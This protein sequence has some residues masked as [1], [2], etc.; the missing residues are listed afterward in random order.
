MFLNAKFKTYEFLLE[1]PIKIKDLLQQNKQ[2]S[3]APNT[4]R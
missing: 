2:A 4:V 3:A 1:L